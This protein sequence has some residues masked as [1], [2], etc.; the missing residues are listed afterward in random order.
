VTD[1]GSAKESYEVADCKKC[2]RSIVAFMNCFDSGGFR[3]TDETSSED[4]SSESISLSDDEL[5]YEIGQQNQTE[6][7][8]TV[9]CC[10]CGC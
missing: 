7:G 3:A 2:C 8:F 9:F 4:E 10:F 1:A 6:V 5:Q